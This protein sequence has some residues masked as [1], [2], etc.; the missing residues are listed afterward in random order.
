MG[1]GGDKAFHPFVKVELH[2][3]KPEEGM[4]KHK[5]HSA[6][7]DHPDFGKDGATIKFHDVPKVV[8][9]LSFVR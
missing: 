1:T 2:V 8:E 5:T 9:E 3:D 6:A 4:Y 7:T